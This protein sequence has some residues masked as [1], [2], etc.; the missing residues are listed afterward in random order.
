MK[1]YTFKLFLQR[2]RCL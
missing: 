2:N 1:V